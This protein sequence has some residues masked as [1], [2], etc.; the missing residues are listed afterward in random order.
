MLMY[1]LN[2]SF[3]FKDTA[4]ITVDKWL[5]ELKVN[6][7]DTVYTFSLTWTNMWTLHHVCLVHIPS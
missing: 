2:I 5:D 4:E 3:I 6:R 7:D 1:Y